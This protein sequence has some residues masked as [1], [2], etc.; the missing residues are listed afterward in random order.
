[1]F[2]FAPISVNDMKNHTH[3]SFFNRR[4]KIENFREAEI[5]DFYELQPPPPRR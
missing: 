4:E 3:T 2:T 1:M 5:F